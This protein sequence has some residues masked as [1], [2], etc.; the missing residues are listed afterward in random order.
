MSRDACATFS[1]DESEEN[2]KKPSYFSQTENARGCLWLWE[3]L[4]WF[5]LNLPWAQIYSSGGTRQVKI[6][7]GLL[8]LHSHAN[9]LP[10]AHW[11]AVAW[12]GDAFRGQPIINLF[13]ILFRNSKMYPLSWGLFPPNSTTVLFNHDGRCKIALRMFSK[14]WVRPDKNRRR[15]LK[16]WKSVLDRPSLP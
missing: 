2:E 9:S 4:L 13:R 11:N 3:A 12:V 14:L 5:W 1:L 16:S 15:W 10:L 8:L 7:I 6:E